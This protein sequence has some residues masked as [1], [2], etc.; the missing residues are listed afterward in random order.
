MNTGKL[1]VLAKLWTFAALWSELTFA[2]AQ[3]PRGESGMADGAD[4]LGA[5]WIFVA[6]AIFAAF[7]KSQKTGLQTLVFFAVLGGVYVVSPVI[8]GILFGV[9]CLT[10]AFSFFIK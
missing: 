3:V 8:G 9:L 10:V 7:K 5:I 1:Q 2:V 6:F 4:A